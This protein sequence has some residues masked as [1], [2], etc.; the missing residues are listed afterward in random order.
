MISEK[1]RMSVENTTGKCNMIF[2]DNHVGAADYRT[3][4]TWK[5][6]KPVPKCYTSKYHMFMADSTPSNK[7]RI[8]PI[9]PPALRR[10][11]F[12][13]ETAGGKFYA[14]KRLKMPFQDI[15]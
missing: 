5:P 14:A 10:H 12:E 9:L 1:G 3:V 7:P 13:R 4:M 6:D 8:L 2:M 11:A 15:N